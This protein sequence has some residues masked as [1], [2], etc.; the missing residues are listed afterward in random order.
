MNQKNKNYKG[1]MKLLGTT[2]IFKTVY[3]STKW[4]LYPTT[5][6]DLAKKIVLEKKIEAEVKAIAIGYI[7]EFFS[8]FISFG[9]SKTEVLKLNSEIDQHKIKS[10]VHTTENKIA[11][12][13]EE[14]RKIRIIINN[15]YSIEDQIIKTDR[16]F[17]VSIG[18]AQGITL[19]VT[20]TKQLIPKNCIGIFPTSGVKYTTQ[21]LKCV[22]IIFLNGAVTS[23]GAILAREFGIPAI[24][25]PSFK[26]EDGKQVSI[27][28]TSGIAKVVDISL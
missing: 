13:L 27:D 21:F 19:N 12:A 8:K 9:K 26:I 16:S 18:T 4:I 7:N 11:K 17:G 5:A 2:N 6:V 23:H 28:G 20:D 24:V 14:L 22:G 3:L 10:N 15:K 1:A 25:N